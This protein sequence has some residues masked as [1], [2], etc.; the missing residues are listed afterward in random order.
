MKE[1]MGH[2][3]VSSIKGSSIHCNHTRPGEKEQEKIHCN[4]ANLNSAVA[5]K[6]V[7]NK[8]RTQIFQIVFEMESK[9]NI[10]LVSYSSKL[11][12]GHRR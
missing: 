8:T 2:I 5:S 4:L 11:L 7:I 9:R 6:T 1:K 10:F 3:G 12:N